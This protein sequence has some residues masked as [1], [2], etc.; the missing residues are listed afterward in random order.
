MQHFRPVRLRDVDITG[1]FWAKKQRLNHEVT[2]KAVE[3]RFRDT[4]RFEAF[5]FN[6]TPDS[7]LPQPH[8]F[9]DS[10]VVKWLEGAAYI[11]EKTGDEELIRKAEELID[12]IEKNQG[13]DGYFNIYHTVVEPELRFKNR[14]HHELYCLG[15]MIEAA[16]A[17]FEATGSERLIGVCDRYIDLVIKA[18]VEEKTAS[19]TTPGHEEIE[20]ALFKLYRC[21]GDEKYL[22]LARFFLDQRGVADDD[23]MSWCNS[24]YMQSHKPVR[25]QREAVGH[26]VRACY[27]Y[28]GMADEAAECS[29]EEM[30]TA[31]E[32][33]FDDIYFHK[34]YVTGGIG[35]THKGEAF[36]IPYDLPNDTAY[37]E[38]CASIALG[39][40]ADR[41]KNLVP[42]ARYADVVELEAYNGALAGLSLDGK[43]FFYE[44]PLEINLADRH[45]HISVN[46]AERL[47]ITRRQEVFG[48]SCCP[49]N[50]NRYIANINESLYLY[51]EDTIV[52]HQF[53]SSEAR[54]DGAA[55]TVRTDYP[56]DGKI[57]I[58][59]KGAA[60]R[61]L[62]VRVPG[63]C[64]EFSFD[65][66][67]TLNGGYAEIKVDSDDFALSAEFV[68]KPRFIAANPAVRADAGKAALAYGPIVY[69][70]EGADNS[71]PL[72][73]VTVDTGSAP[74]IAF[75][76]LFGCNTLTFD[77]F[78]PAAIG[79][80][81]PLYGTFGKEETEPV[82]VTF[83]PY[84]CYANREECDMAVWFRAR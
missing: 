7:G 70:L 33:L 83:I 62:L 35:S 30:L 34:L 2:I 32:A 49:P 1:G 4:G 40:F 22:R 42:D 20:L 13:E 45:R 36:T 68:M 64:D 28:C 51:S 43:A 53:A 71:F 76:E 26:S 17:Y 66:E 59:L 25:E 9:W 19:F 27:L 74:E 50:V 58:A 65:R 38:T 15:H 81:A 6:W 3:D 78:L 44:N 31:C 57:K 60:G 8:F 67:Y 11:I 79:D 63:W 47:P 54:I 73:A 72:Y 80:E 48:C 24:A 16:V 23:V 69:C 82:K 52:I 14:D 77:G 10:D 56:A 46:D 5:K 84:H 12:L 61:K 18:F 75:D 37:C 55:L 41:M 29:D 39:F 21:R